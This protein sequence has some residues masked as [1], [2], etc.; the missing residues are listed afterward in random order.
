M[1]LTD[2]TPPAPVTLTSADRILIASVTDVAI[3]VSQQGIYAAN[4]AYLGASRTLHVWWHSVAYGHAM[5]SHAIWFGS[6][7]NRIRFEVI[8]ARR[9]LQS[10]LA[11]PEACS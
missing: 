6:D 3:D 2:L 10:L 7:A 11:R 9:E 5:G 1:S 4:V 8:A